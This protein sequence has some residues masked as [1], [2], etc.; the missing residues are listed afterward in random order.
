MIDTT[1]ASFPPTPF[2][3]HDSINSGS[4]TNYFN[5]SFKSLV[6]Q[7]MMTSARYIVLGNMNVQ[8]D[9][10]TSPSSSSPRMETPKSQPITINF[11]RRRDQR[12]SSF[13][14][15][16]VTHLPARPLSRRHV[17][18]WNLALNDLEDEMDDGNACSRSGE[19]DEEVFMLE[20]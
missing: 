2:A 3:T 12:T 4:P 7:T 10:I 6:K 20:L 11:G 17:H 14:D 13:D 1:M 16:L 15:D 18:R 8:A 19:D 9:S 5:D